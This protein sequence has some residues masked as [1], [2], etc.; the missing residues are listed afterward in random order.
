M[1]ET[2]R[3]YL[4]LYFKDNRLTITHLLSNFDS[5]WLVLLEI[6]VLGGLTMF[7]AGGRAA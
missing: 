4:Y 3:T 5:I 7:L 2:K 1:P 6:G